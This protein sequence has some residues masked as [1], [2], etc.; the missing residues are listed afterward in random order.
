MSDANDQH[1][2]ILREQE[3]RLAAKLSTVRD[4]IAEMEGKGAT[5]P[6]AA[7]WDEWVNNLLPARCQWCDKRFGNDRGVSAHLPHCHAHRLYEQDPEKFLQWVEFN[8]S[9]IG[10][11]M[12]KKREAQA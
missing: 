6:V 8:V 5:A 10:E 11:A 1:L 4:R 2:A 9:P 12:L 3:T 7:G